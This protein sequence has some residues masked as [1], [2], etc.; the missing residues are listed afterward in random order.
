[1]AK[2]SSP[3]RNRSLRKK[4]S[5]QLNGLLASATSQL[6]VTNELRERARA[7]PLQA[8]LN[9][10]PS[11]RLSHAFFSCLYDQIPRYNLSIIGP[12]ASQIPMRLGSS[13]ALDAAA[14]CMLASHSA[15]VRGAAPLSRINP[16]LYTNAL[17]CVQCALDDP[18]EWKSSNTLCAILLLQRIEVW[19][20]FHPNLLL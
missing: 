14:A 19:T 20:V 18:K 10:T 4:D 8:I 6:A 16:K 1:M 7:F 11:E 5:T 9:L 3:K 13:A 12:F 2:R 17:R 15:I